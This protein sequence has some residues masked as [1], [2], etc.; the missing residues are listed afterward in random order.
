MSAIVSMTY[1]SEGSQETL[2]LTAQD[3][4]LILGGYG[5]RNSGD[6]AILAGLLTQLPDVRKVR[7]VSRLPAETAAMH[8][9]RAVSPLLTLPSLLRS[10]VLVV[11]GG[12]IFSADTGPFGRFIPL[13]CRIA[14]ALG[15]RVA[16]H[17]VGV[18]ASTS[19]G[20]MRSLIALAPRLESLTVRDAASVRALAAL[21][22][23]ARQIDDLSQALEPAPEA[24]SRA[25]LSAAGLD[26][27]RPI[28]AL[29]LTRLNQPLAAFLRSAIPALVDA[30]PD[31]QFCFV[32]ISRHQTNERHDDLNFAR[33]LALASPR[34]KLIDGVHHPALVL[35][36]FRHFS[37]AVCVR[38]H[39][40][41]FAHRMGAPI[42]ALPYADKC[43][44]WLEE[45]GISPIERTE[46]ALIDA[47]R[48][49]VSIRPPSKWAVVR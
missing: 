6:E 23:P 27:D 17:G 25:L 35:G 12:G 1:R 16:F 45:H 10:D 14:L 40:F 7:V 20:L 31:V 19:K 48:D 5:V 38:F 13:V 22:V 28:V 42:I 18:Y 21:G 46:A 8:G 43:E 36:L 44:S 9:V 33:Y 49:A 29:C 37:A 47:V 30:L 3:R 32:P 2:R 39:S 41:L 34:L 11:G 24:A 26:P 4:V 15:K